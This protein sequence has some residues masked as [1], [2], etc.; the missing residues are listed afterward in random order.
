MHLLWTAQAPVDTCPLRLQTLIPQLLL[1][2]GA[3]MHAK[4]KVR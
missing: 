4:D 1:A 3:D 2:S